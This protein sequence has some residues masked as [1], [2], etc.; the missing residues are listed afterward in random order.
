MALPVSVA[1]TTVSGRYT[2]WDGRPCVGAVTFTPSVCRLIADDGTIIAGGKTVT[3]DQ[4]GEFTTSLVSSHQDAVAPYDFCYFVTEETSCYGCARSYTISTACGTESLV[5][6]MTSIDAWNDVTY[7][8]AAVGNIGPYTDPS[9]S[10]QAALAANGYRTIEYG[11]NIPYDPDLLYKVTYRVRTDRAPTAGVPYVYLGLTGIAAD[12]A[13][14]VNTFGVDSLTNQH[15][16]AARRSDLTPSAQYTTFTGYVTGHST[17]SND[18]LIPHPDPDL[19]GAMHEST[20]FMRP[21]MFLLYQCSGGF[22]LVDSVSITPICKLDLSD[23]L[24]GGGPY[25]D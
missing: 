1:T 18:G 24:S 13:T 6:H 25:G 21:L 12:G 10:D 4:N 22:Q 14:R 7:D 3:L 8:P 5:D 15:Y 19:P 20:A 9:A 17:N 23:V 11:R 16:L 2:Q